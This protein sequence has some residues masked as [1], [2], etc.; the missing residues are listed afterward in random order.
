M[1]ACLES[2]EISLLFRPDWRLFDREVEKLVSVS[3]GI[4]SATFTLAAEQVAHFV[5]RLWLGVDEEQVLDY[6]RWRQADAA[7]C[8]LNGWCYWSLRKAGKSVSQATSALRGQSVAA[9]HELL[10]QHGINFNDL[11]AWQ[12]RGSGLSWEAYEKVGYDPI[13]AKEVTATRRRVQVNEELPMKEAYDA[14]LRQMIT[15]KGG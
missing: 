7:R 1:N 9:K 10:F 8:A 3:A 15:F 11:P 13:Q 14:W 6:F 2:D 5:S 12:R 4:A